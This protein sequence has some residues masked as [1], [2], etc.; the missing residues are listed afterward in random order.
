MNDH[1]ETAKSDDDD[2][3]K[4]LAQAIILAAATAATTIIVKHVTIKLL[5]RHADKTI[6]WPKKKA[7]LEA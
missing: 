2:F 4:E 1:I 3:S 7:T 5:A 6:T